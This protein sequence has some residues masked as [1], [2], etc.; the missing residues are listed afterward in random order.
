M[1]APSDAPSGRT[2][3][4]I[5]IG[6][7]L[8][9]L[10][11]WAFAANYRLVSVF[12]L[13]NPADVL[14]ALIETIA[15]GEMWRHLRVTLTEL[16]IAFS[17]NSVLATVVGFLV[18]RSLNSTIVF[19]PIFAALFSIP[20]ILF[21]PINVLIFGIGMESKIVQGALFGFFP[22]VLHT[23]AGFSSVN[24]T[25]IRF[26][27]VTGASQRQILTRILMPAAMPVLVGGYRIGFILTFL[28]IISAETITSLEGLGNRIV[29][30]AEILQTAEM[31]AF[32]VVIIALAFL[33]NIALRML[34]ERWK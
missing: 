18:T 21:Y 27:R 6:F 22:I 13:P 20:I 12:F 26:A 23:I 10:A 8:V 4:A 32:I 31:F 25:L 3:A 34:E 1:S 33:M 11:G 7:V 29:W 15:S 9:V 14:D 19:E 5:Q 30:H 28:S 16:A 2:A 24:P 17:L